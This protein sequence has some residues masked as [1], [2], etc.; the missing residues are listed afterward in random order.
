MLSSL[1]S[2]ERC[3]D[4][5][6]CCRLLVA[7]ACLIFRASGD[8]C[9]LMRRR[10]G[11]SGSGGGVGC[12][13]ALAVKSSGVAFGFAGAVSGSDNSVSSASMTTLLWPNWVRL[14]SDRRRLRRCGWTA[15]YSLPCVRYRY[16]H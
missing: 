16:T 7:A 4:E 8:K 3:L 11:D 6:S 9:H 1:S 15:S 13:R 14:I 12:C 5:R 10:D 2:N